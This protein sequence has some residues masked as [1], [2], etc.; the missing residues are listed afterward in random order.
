MAKINAKAAKIIDD[1]SYVSKIELCRA[2]SSGT[3]ISGVKVTWTNFNDGTVTN[4]VLD[5]YT[6]SDCPVD[7][8]IELAAKDCITR[9]NVVF[10]ANGNGHSIIY[11]R[12]MGESEESLGFGTVTESDFSADDVPS[13]GCLSGYNMGWGAP[14][15]T[16]TAGA[17]RYGRN[18][19][20]VNIV[21]LQGIVTISSDGIQE[22]LMV[23]EVST[24]A[25]A[26]TQDRIADEV[27]KA[28]DDLKKNGINSMYFIPVV[29]LGAIC[30]GV[31]FYM[32]QMNTV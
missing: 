13:S 8:V 20:E 6:D 27:A 7:K 15:T 24:S 26:I 17:S 11:R 29:I 19:A 4:G 2:D 18:L 16:P 14:A 30:V 25:L 1:F 5:G 3:A 32:V 21:T 23:T 10:D 22:D 9:F 28:A 31:Y 12:R